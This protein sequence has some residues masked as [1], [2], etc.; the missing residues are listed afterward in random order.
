MEKKED[1]KVMEPNTVKKHFENIINALDIA[2]KKGLYSL[3]QS[4][5]IFAS[6]QHINEFLD[7][8]TETVNKSINVMPPTPFEVKSTSGEMI[9]EISLKPKI[10]DKE[11]IQI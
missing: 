3:G 6:L 4:A 11:T 1:D 5:Y 10:K 2:Q 9:P 8:Q 7:K